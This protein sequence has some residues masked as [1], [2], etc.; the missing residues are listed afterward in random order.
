MKTIIATQ[1]I[2]QLVIFCK[3]GNGKYC[4]DFISRNSCTH[5]KNEIQKNNGHQDG[6]PHTHEEFFWITLL[7]TE[8]KTTDIYFLTYD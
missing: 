5:L 1:K 4:C 3:P 8:M 2:Y 7:F 6:R